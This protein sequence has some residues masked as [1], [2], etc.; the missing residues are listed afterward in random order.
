MKSLSEISQVT[1]DVY[2]KKLAIFARM[3][4]VTVVLLNWLIV[5]L[6]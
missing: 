4:F 3:P 2:L 6:I 5:T 1:A